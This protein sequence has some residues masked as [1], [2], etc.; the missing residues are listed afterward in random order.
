VDQLWFENSPAD[1][2]GIRLQWDQEGH[3]K[4]RLWVVCGDGALY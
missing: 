4:R 3:E 2:M 1:A